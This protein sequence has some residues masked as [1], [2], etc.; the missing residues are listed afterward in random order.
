MKVKD[1]LTVCSKLKRKHLLVNVKKKPTKLSVLRTSENLRELWEVQALP[2]D[3]D[4]DTKPSNAV[5]VVMKKRQEKHN[6]IITAMRND[7]ININ[8]ETEDDIR[9]ASTIY[10][11]GLSDSK[12][13]IGDCLQNI[14]QILKGRTVPE[15]RPAHTRLSDSLIT[16]AIWIPSSRNI[17]V[18]EH[19][20]EE[21]CTWFNS[22]ALEDAIFNTHGEVIVGGDFNAKAM[23]HPNSRGRYI[24][25]MMAKTELIVLNE[26]E[27]TTFH[28]PGYSE[29]IPDVYFASVALAPRIVDWKVSENYTGSDHQVIT[30]TVYGRPEASCR[31]LPTPG[32]WNLGKLDAE[33][34]SIGGIASACDAS[35]TRKAPR[36]CRR[37]AYWWTAEIAELRGRCL[38]LKRIAQGA[39]HRKGANVRFAEQR[40]PE[41]ALQRPINES[42]ARHWMDM[43]SDVDSDP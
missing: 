25:E 10:K 34:F 39:G 38:R 21:G 36:H 7:M 29:T 12:M 1:S 20:S 16:S 3:W 26:R 11:Q 33:R 32:G 6:H 8:T 9:A 17:Q 19:G 27:V 37:A 43:V 14:R 42:K 22:S 40:E 4:P 31:F 15:P 23:P 35:M 2:S 18:E 30:F 13:Q 5:Q 41:K 28:R 24:L